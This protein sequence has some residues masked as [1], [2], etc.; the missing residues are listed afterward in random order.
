MGSK[1]VRTEFGS[2]LICLRAQTCM[3][4]KVVR[5][6]FG[7]GLICPRAQTCCA[8]KSSA[9]SGARETST[10]TPARLANSPEFKS[11]RCPRWRIKF[12]LERFQIHRESACVSSR[13]KVLSGEFRRRPTARAIKLRNPDR[14]GRRGLSEP[15]EDFS[16]LITYAFPR[17]FSA[18]VFRGCCITRRINQRKTAPC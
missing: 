16:R 1:V 6:D 10:Q 13:W 7:S 8:L 15:R 9:P 12:S 17:L 18:A 14:V 2:G 11:F 3:D 4:S 5:T